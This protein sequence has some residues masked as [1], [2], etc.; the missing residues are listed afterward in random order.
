MSGRGDIRA[1]RAFVELFLKNNLTG[2]L[3][4]AL[5]GV[6]KQLAQMAGGVRFVAGQLNALSGVATKAG[7]GITAPFAFAVSRLPE[8]KKMFGE[9]GDAITEGLGKPL[10]PIVKLVR[11][12]VVRFSEWAKANPQVVVTLFKIDRADGCQAGG[13]G[14]GQ[15]G[16]CG[17]G[18]IGRG[19]GG[20]RRAGGHRR[21]RGLAAGY[22]GNALGSKCSGLAA[23]HQKRTG[24]GSRRRAIYG[25]AGG[26]S[27]NDLRRHR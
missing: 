7:L 2:Q 13:S 15:R 20:S 25:P 24:G 11:D 17:R 18:W 16:D 21:I 22:R 19:I 23:V 6:K 26:D 5:L 14:A 4:K 12:V 27:E 8:A 10:L 3:S 1:G 9:M